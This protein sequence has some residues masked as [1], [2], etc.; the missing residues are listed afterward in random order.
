MNKIQFDQVLM[1]L[2]VNAY[3]AIKQKGIIT[4]KTDICSKNIEGKYNKNIEDQYKKNTE[5]EGENKEKGYKREYIK[6]TIKDT[7]CGIDK[8]D[9]P[10]IFEPFFTTKEEEGTGLGLSI[11]YSIIKQNDG[12]I[13]VDSKIHVGT[14]FY[15][16]LPIEKR[17]I[18]DEKN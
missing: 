5:N 9:L 10:K 11:V 13:E 7:G 1:N 14:S 16:Y 12:Y 6:I 3:D 8:N 4:I 15:I 18:S 2:L 17:E